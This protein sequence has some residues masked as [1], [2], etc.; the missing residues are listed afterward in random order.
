M[1]VC[2][3]CKNLRRSADRIKVSISKTYLIEE[4]NREVTNIPLD[5]CD[6]CLT[7]FMK[8]I[9]FE[10][11]KQKG[12]VPKIN[13]GS[14]EKEEQMNNRKG[15]TLVELLVVIVIV[16]I[17]V[18]LLVPAV[19]RAKHTATDAAVSAEIR[20]LMAGLANFKNEHG[21][22]PPS[23]IVFAEDG[24]YSDDNLGDYKQLKNRSVLYLRKFWPRLALRTDGSK[25][26]IPGGWYDFNGDHVRNAPYVI[27]GHECLVMF[28]GGV[29]SKGENG[30]FA[31]TGFDKN[32]MNPFTSNDPPPAGKSW[33]F[34]S[35]RNPGFDFK[36]G[37]LVASTNKTVLPA[38]SSLVCYLDIYEN[39]LV[40]FSAYNG[41]GYDPDDVDFQEENQWL[42]GAFQTG[43]AASPVLK[44][45]RRDIV[46]S[47]G[48]NPYTNDSPIP[49]DSGGNFD[50]KNNRNVQ[51]YNTNTFQILS[52][53]RDKLWGVGGNWNE[54]GTPTI[55][56]YPIANESVTGMKLDMSVRNGEKDNLADFAMGGLD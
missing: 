36:A 56:F 40:Y 48:P 6:Q 28:L 14:N 37:R 32:P 26:P 8:F 16:G 13:V 43:N 29:P 46:T 55:P 7:D 30:K 4:N 34:G 42:L 9:G 25:P 44:T 24:D 2:D 54:K 39:P 3:F 19:M 20:G 11:Q 5:L 27:Y 15:F 10:I 51:Y 49:V 33:P 12:T 35:S 22:L 21:D 38:S 41:V 47:A 50:I 53:G 31:M 45:T 17:L 18:S 52:A 1:V 23:R